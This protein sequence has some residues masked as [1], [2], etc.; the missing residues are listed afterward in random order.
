M[1]ARTYEVTTEDAEYLRHGDKGL[2][3][4]LYKPRGDGPF[5]A[6]IDLHGGAWTS[7]DLAECQG[8]DEALAQAGFVVVALN[9]RQAGDGY[10]ASLADINYGIRWVKTRAAD[11]RT[12][13]DLVGIA[14]QSSGGHLAMLA[15]MRPRDA[16]Y[17]AIPTQSGAR[18]RRYGAWQCC[19]R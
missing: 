11:L 17:A 3:L 13:P 15:A 4:R 14:G 8:R 5:P 9:F 7:G 10:P 16:R 1:P 18:M 2:T 12:R 19:G 6:V